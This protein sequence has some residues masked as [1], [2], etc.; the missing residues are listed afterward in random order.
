MEESEK[1]VEV[2]GKKSWG[3]KPSI[4]HVNLLDPSNSLSSTF[5]RIDL[6]PLYTTCLAVECHL[7]CVIFIDT[8]GE[9]MQ[10]QS[11]Q[12]PTKDSGFMYSHT[13]SKGI[14]SKLG[15]ISLAR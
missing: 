3:F 7:E 11:V 2:F 5:T 9:E 14:I 8:T 12:S 6:C 4:R 1:K 10:T 13:D 15:S